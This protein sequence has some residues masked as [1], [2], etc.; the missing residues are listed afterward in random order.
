MAG[1]F[2]DHFESKY[3]KPSAEELAKAKKSKKDK[4][5]KKDDKDKEK[6]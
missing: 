4:D 5:K 2:K 6:D 1:S 3:G